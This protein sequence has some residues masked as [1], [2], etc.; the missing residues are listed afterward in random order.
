MKASTS[1]VSELSADDLVPLL[2]LVLV[3]CRLETLAL[4]AF[5]LDACL[6][7]VLCSGR[8]EDVVCTMQ[9]AVGFLREVIVS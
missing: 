1:R 5:L 2:T 6:S 8:E 7:D 3:A 9:V 4:D